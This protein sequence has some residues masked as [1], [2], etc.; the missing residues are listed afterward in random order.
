MPV[1]W[2]QRRSLEEGNSTEAAA[3]G[4]GQWRERPDSRECSRVPQT[5]S[6]GMAHTSWSSK[7]RMNIGKPV[8]EEVSVS[9]TMPSVDSD[10]DVGPYCSGADR[11]SMVRRT[12]TTVTLRTETDFHQLPRLVPWAA[13]EAMPLWD[14]GQ[15]KLAHTTSE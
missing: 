11:D 6:L 12:W 2:L 3:D 7:G 15:Q 5:C 8:K 10:V 1:E 9:V 4:K 13:L 14:R